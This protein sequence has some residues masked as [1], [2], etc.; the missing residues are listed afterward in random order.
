VGR[1]K[2]SV[3]LI[4]FVLA[5]AKRVCRSWKQAILEMERRED[6]WKTFVHQYFSPVLAVDHA[7]RKGCFSFVQNVVDRFR[8][9]YGCLRRISDYT[10]SIGMHSES[11]LCHES[12]ILVETL[13]FA[14]LGNRLRLRCRPFS[15]PIKNDIS[16]VRCHIMLK[17]HTDD[18]HLMFKVQPK[19]GQKYG[20]FELPWDEDSDS[21]V[22]SV[23]G[24]D[25]VLALVCHHINPPTYD[26]C[27]PMNFDLIALIKFADANANS[28]LTE[29]DLRVIGFHL[30]P[31]KYLALDAYS[32]RLAPGE[33]LLNW[34]E[35]H[36][37]T[38]QHWM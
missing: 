12:P 35:Y 17:R 3:K 27:D 28:D 24:E 19:K 11:F 14:T 5:R 29:Q 13:R 31:N 18:R 15:L 8:L 23:V 30:R 25:D 32:R 4:F 36:G 9:Q 10:I 16:E 22:D 2:R 38:N 20:V 7:A 21:D 34:L 1:G 33:A 26:I 6:T 37:E